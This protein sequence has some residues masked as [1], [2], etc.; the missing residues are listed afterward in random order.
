MSD[1]FKDVFNYEHIIKNKILNMSEKEKLKRFEELKNNNK[2]LYDETINLLLLYCNDNDE[3]LIGTY[4]SM[5]IKS[6]NDY[7]VVVEILYLVQ[8]TIWTESDKY[9]DNL[10]SIGMLGAYSEMLMKTNI[11]LKNIKKNFDN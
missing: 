6:E 4:N 7:K 9:K 11:V 5:M 8:S 1:I 2:R 3:E 10:Y